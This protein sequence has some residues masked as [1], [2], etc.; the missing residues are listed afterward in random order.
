MWHIS[1]K[2]F[3]SRMKK[4][5]DK[6]KSKER[7]EKLKAEKNKFKQKPK[8]ETSKLLAIYLF[9]I[10]NVI[11][12]YSMVAMW[13]FEDISYLSVLIT[14][15]IGQILLFG[16]YCLKAYNGK[17]QEE[18]IKFEREKLLNTISTED[19]NDIGADI[20]LSDYGIAG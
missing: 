12:V 1:E 3:D 7:K 2:E 17:K 19:I 6:N 18:K 20:D 14:D 16:I 9:F 5:K 13:V 15:I 4:I 8:T 11:L 10:F